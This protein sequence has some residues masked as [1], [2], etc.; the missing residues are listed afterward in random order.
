MKK[1]IITIGFFI[2]LYIVRGQVDINP[3]DYH[4]GE[5]PTTTEA[6]DLQFKDYQSA[7]LKHRYLLYF[8]LTKTEAQLW[9]L[10]HIAY[11]VYTQ[12]GVSKLNS[13]NFSDIDITS[14]KQFEA[15]VIRNNEIIHEYNQNHFV[16]ITNQE[17]EEEE[18]SLATYEI[19]LPDLAVGDIVE[20][21]GIRIR[22]ELNE[23]ET[24]YLH[25]D[26]PSKD[27]DYTIIMP[28][29]LK[30]HV[31]L[32]NSEY[33]VIDSIV[34]HLDLRY[35]TIH[36][37]FLPA[38]PN[39]PFA[40]PD[41][42]LARVEYNLAYNYLYGNQRV[43]T[44]KYFVN[45]FYE[46]SKLSDPTLTKIV[47]KELIK[48]LKINKKDPLEQQLR[49][50]ETLLKRE[51]YGVNK[52]IQ[53]KIYSYILDHFKINYEIVLTTDKT[54]KTFDKNF[55]GFNFYKEILFYFPE[56]DQY[57]APEYF[58]LR[59]GLTP[60][61]LTGNEALFCKKA[62]IGK[63]E[64]FTYY[65]GT[66]P[67]P[68]KTT[69]IDNIVL[70]LD[71]SSDLKTLYGKI[72]RETSG[73]LVSFIQANYDYFEIEDREQLVEELMTL[74]SDGSLISDETFTHTSPQ[75][76]GVH[77]LIGE[78][79]ISNS[80]WVRMEGDDLIISVGEM[81][82][83]QG[84]IESKQSRVLPVE[85]NYLS[86]YR[87]S[88]SIAIPQ[89]YRVDDLAQYQVEIYDNDDPQKAKAAFT[90]HFK[91]E[92]DVLKVECIEY[93]DQLYYDIEAYPLIERVVNGAADFNQLKV[94]LVKK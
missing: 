77:P 21:Y 39:E 37:P 41:K 47:K 9:E 56:I 34:T 72:K 7:T 63:T 50:I 3:K 10:K 61:V 42:Y 62:K 1:I 86:S 11:K 38:I 93:Y 80:S 18:E 14:F 48:Q 17:E 40:H 24:Y 16:K 94:R 69:T 53:L 26:V 44:T 6:E 66:I 4:F 30:P 85:R 64:L 90:A 52:I 67:V 59:L 29:H 15:R 82:G 89:G 79:S 81:I 87:R 83:K 12:E 32:Y 46:L 57:I 78:G 45:N 31:Q 92:N 25:G 8:H 68:K 91:V 70:S 75:D 60:A 51:L 76:I 23:M 20:F 22:P 33:P 54:K 35:T 2:S 19:K 13:I 36:I 73:Y 27:I 49:T 28:D 74:S 55:N 88:I 5:L 65:F 58:A 84:K 43:N 71:F